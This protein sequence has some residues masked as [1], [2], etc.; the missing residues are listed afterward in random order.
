MRGAEPRGNPG[1]YPSKREVYPL[2]LHKN[3]KAVGKV[4]ISPKSVE[5]KGKQN[6]RRLLETLYTNL[7]GHPER[8]STLIG[9][10]Q[11]LLDQGSV[12][13]KKLSLL[14]S[15]TGQAKAQLAKVSRFFAEQDVDH[16]V[17]SYFIW[18]FIQ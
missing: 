4:H 6:E 10:I 1:P 13:L 3:Q 5:R 11:G 7:G 12:K 16:A 18:N 17:F 14:V 8:I 9:I 2:V 15:S